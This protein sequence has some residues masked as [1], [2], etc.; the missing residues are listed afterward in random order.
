MNTIALQGLLMSDPKTERGHVCALNE[1]PTRIT[2]VPALYI[3]NSQPRTK[4]GQHW[5]ALYI[6]ENGPIEFFDSLERHPSYYQLDVM[7]FITNEHRYQQVGTR[8]CGHYFYYYL[9][10]RCTGRSMRDILKDF[11]VED[12]DKNETLVTDFVNS[13]D[14]FDL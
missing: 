2:E 1:L 13:M 5:L 9:Y 10:Q 6:P 8:S 14:I 11:D 7:N 3:V 12:L 4:R